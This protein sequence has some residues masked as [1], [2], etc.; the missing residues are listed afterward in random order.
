[1]ANQHKS[2]DITGYHWMPGLAVISLF[3]DSWPSLLAKA[4][5]LRQRHSDKLLAALELGMQAR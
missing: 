2:L 3:S 5:K 1:M 4:V